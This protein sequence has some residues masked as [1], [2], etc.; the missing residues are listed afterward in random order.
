MK[1]IAFISLFFLLT[2][3]H[4]N[5]NAVGGTVGGWRIT[6]NVAQGIG[7]KI[8]ATKDVI[9]NGAS[10]AV[11]SS[12]SV[13]PKAADVGKFMGKNLGAAAVVGAMDLLL[14]GVDYVMDPANNS[15]TYKP[16][17]CSTN[18]QYLYQL[19]TRQDTR[20]STPQ[21]V[22]Q[23]LM[24]INYW[25]GGETTSSTYSASK[26]TCERT[27]TYAGSSYTSTASQTIRTV[28]NPSYDESKEEERKSVPLSTIGQQVIDQAQSEVQAGNPAQSAAVTRAV[29]QDMIQ[30]AEADDVKARPIAQELDKNPTYPTTE[31]G[32]GTITQPE[33]VDPATGE[34]VKPAEQ[35]SIKFT[36]P[37][38]CEWFPQAC[39]FIDWVRTDPE[40]ESEM[41]L[42]EKE[43]EKH[44]IDD[45]LIKASGRSCPADI[46]F[47][48]DGLPF[49][50]TAPDSFKMQPVCDVLEPLKYVFV[51]MT[52]CLC[53]FLLVR[54]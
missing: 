27:Y 53:A 16:K 28:A 46:T 14:D 33:V 15:V 54:F 2:S 26:N 21:Q 17:Q 25:Q 11:T 38:A 30:Q 8:T 12:A 3:G 50:I 19:G 36:F 47:D 7:A 32:E 31:E 51:F 44:Q 52:T 40:V 1:N 9:I 29:A 24:S 10:K 6:S 39:E 45:D 20:A 48:V 5:A 43:I 22:C 23:N 35:S 18:C 13:L 4:T 34:V 42:P 37:K 41:E 49:G